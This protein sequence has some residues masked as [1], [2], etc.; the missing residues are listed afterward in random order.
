MTPFILM[1]AL[2]THAVFE[3]MALGLQSS[4]VNT[5]NIIIAICLHKWAASMSLG[6]SLGKT[7]VDEDSKKIF[8]ML[9]IFA[10]ATPFGVSIGIILQNA[11]PE[12]VDIICSSI[13]GGT[14]VYIA[15]SEVVVE[16]FSVPG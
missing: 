5:I 13:A 3:G 10:L 7:F 11:A 1:I 15:C 9:L 4:A 6:V 8:W 16:E 12:I 14:F 2:S